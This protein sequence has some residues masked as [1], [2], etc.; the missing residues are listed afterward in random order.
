MIVMGNRER[1]ACNNQFLVVAHHRRQRR[2]MYCAVFARQWRP[3]TT[4]R[5]YHRHARM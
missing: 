4:T 1:T 3:R 5:F 2:G